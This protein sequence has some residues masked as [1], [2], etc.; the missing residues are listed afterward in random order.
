MAAV[1]RAYW[2]VRAIFVL[3]DDWVHP[4]RDSNGDPRYALASPGPHVQ[5]IATIQAAL[6]QAYAD[7]PP[8][9]QDVL[10]PRVERGV[11]QHAT[12]TLLYMPFRAAGE[13]W[14]GLRYIRRPTDAHTDSCRRTLEILRK[15]KLSAEE[16]LNHWPCA[17]VSLHKALGSSFLDPCARQ[18]ASIC[19][20]TG[21]CQGLPELQA[22][23]GGL[24]DDFIG[25]LQTRMREGSS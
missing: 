7:C 4:G 17:I 18:L 11:A 6:E 24:R 21:D 22:V 2:C 10:L 13:S 12:L 20:A 5:T 3:D 14:E 8:A 25:V 9:F 16:L 23:A 15:I 1:L 19:A